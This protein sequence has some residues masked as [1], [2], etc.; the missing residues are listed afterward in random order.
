M[1]LRFDYRTENPEAYQTLLKLETSM[2]KSEIYK[3]L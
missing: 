1:S 3:Y 2:R